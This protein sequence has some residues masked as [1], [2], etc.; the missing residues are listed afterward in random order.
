MN[1]SKCHFR[2]KWRFSKLDY[3]L[4]GGSSCFPEPRLEELHK[5]D[6][7]DA[8]GCYGKWGGND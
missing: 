8:G 6:A 2:R 5:R 4:L 3:A 7:N 1:I